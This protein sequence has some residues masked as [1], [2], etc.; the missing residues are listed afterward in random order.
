MKQTA[1]PG[2]LRALWQG[3]DTWQ[4][5]AT[6]AEI[7]ERRSAV[8]QPPRPAKTFQPGHCTPLRPMPILRD[9]GDPELCDEIKFKEQPLTTANARGSFI[10]VVSDFSSVAC[11]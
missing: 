5:S 6:R 2:R 4:R 8:P 7:L 1:W 9:H 11:R 10:G 3:I